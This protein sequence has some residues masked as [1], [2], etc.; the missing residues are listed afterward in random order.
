M[1]DAI[2]T[3]SSLAMDTIERVIAFLGN[4]PRKSLRVEP[5]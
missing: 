2:P 5:S 4:N 3:A 1:R